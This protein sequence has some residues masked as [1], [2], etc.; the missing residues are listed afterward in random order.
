M[1][2]KNIKVYLTL[3]RI[4]IIWIKILVNYFYPLIKLR[5]IKWLITV[6]EEN[7]VIRE[8]DITI[9]QNK[10]AIYFKKP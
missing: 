6:I 9:L 2:N 7:V 5:M 4:K 8:I 10:L 1:T 3:L